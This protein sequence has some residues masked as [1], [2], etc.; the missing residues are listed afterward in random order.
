MTRNLLLVSIS[1]G[2]VILLFTYIQKED[3]KKSYMSQ[4]EDLILFEK[5][6]KELGVLKTKHKDKKLT[7]RIVDA[8]RSIK[9]PA[10]DYKMAGTRVLEFDD[11]DARVLNRLIK[12]IQNST[13]NLTKLDILRDSESSSKLRVEFKQ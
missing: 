1:L 6:A 10:K 13:L 4:K 8:L 11:V 2:I 7:K 3:A 9:S 5:E 12:K